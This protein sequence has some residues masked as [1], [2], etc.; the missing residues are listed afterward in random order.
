MMGSRHRG[1]LR[2]TG[3]RDNGKR[4]GQEGDSEDVLHLHLEGSSLGETVQVPVPGASRR[5]K[6]RWTTRIQWEEVEKERAVWTAGSTSKRV[7]GW[8]RVTRNP[9]E[10]PSK[11]DSINIKMSLQSNGN[12]GKWCEACRASPG[13]QCDQWI[14]HMTLF[15]N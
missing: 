2:R 8:I 9:F 13:R 10:N 15:T 14:G 6:G 7:N 11:S 3:T 5:A 1:Q 12:H 4:S